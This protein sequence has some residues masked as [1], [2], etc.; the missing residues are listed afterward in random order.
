MISDRDD[1][2]FYVPIC[3]N[4]QHKKAGETAFYVVLWEK[5]KTNTKT[6]K[7]RKTRK[8]RFL[9]FSLSGKK[10]KKSG[11][12]KNFRFLFVHDCHWLSLEIKGLIPYT[13]LYGIFRN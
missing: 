4:R 6:A 12:L 13:G 8:A 9:A 1:L 2:D 5:I 11:N 7:S 10:H 3:Y